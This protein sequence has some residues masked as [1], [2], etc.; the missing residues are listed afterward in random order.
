MD[1]PLD[2]QLFLWYTF[3]N[4]KKTM[5]EKI[6]G[7]VLSERVGHRLKANLRT[8]AWFAREFRRGNTSAL[9]YVIGS[10]LSARSLVRIMGGTAEVVLSSLFGE[11]RIFY[12]LNS[13]LS[14][15]MKEF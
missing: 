13:P 11:E 5:N 3:G 14:C 7:L 15:T 1:F 2:F 8:A 10:M 9:S 12:C 6:V 4:I